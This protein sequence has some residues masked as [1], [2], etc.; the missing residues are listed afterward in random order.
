MRDGIYCEAVTLFLQQ[1]L[2]AVLAPLLPRRPVASYTWVVRYRPGAVLERHT[3]RPQCRWNVS[4]CVDRESEQGLPGDWPLWFQL[5][6]GTQ[7]VD[8]GLGDAV[9]YSG[10]ETAHWRERL[11][12]QSAVTMA[13]FH[14]VEDGFKGSLR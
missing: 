10:T 5:D 6:E 12:E 14:Y 3:D 8:L 9:L 2:I 13:L 1:S 4:M 7:R 11:P